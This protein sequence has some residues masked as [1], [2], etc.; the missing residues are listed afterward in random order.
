MTRHEYNS[1]ALT[2]RTSIGT[3]SPCRLWPAVAHSYQRLTGVHPIETSPYASKA[4]LT[5]LNDRNAQIAITPHTTS[6]N[7]AG[8]RLTTT[9][10][11]QQAGISLQVLSPMPVIGEPNRS[12]QPDYI[13]FRRPKAQLDG[14]VCNTYNRCPPWYPDWE[15]QFL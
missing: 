1:T 7:K 12:R 15:G 2:P 10:F 9:S 5:L 13:K 8:E 11:S 3:T 4:A 6:M 14:P